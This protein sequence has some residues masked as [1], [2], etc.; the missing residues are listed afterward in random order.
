MTLMSHTLDTNDAL[1]TRQKLHTPDT[2]DIIVHMYKKKCTIHMGHT[3]H[4]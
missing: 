4:K 2:Q 3:G 1:Y